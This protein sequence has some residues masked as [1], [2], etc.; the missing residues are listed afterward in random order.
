MKVGVIGCGVISRAYVENARAFDSFELVACADLDPAQ[1]IAL[2]KAERPRGRR[3]RRADRRSVDRRHPQP[4]AAA[5]ARRVITSQALAAGKHVYTEK[6]LATDEVEAA[7]LAREAARR[8]LRIGCA[9]DIFLGSA[10]QAG[11]AAIDEGAIGEPLS[12]SAAMLVG[13]QETWHPNPDI[14]YADGAG[15]L[16]DMGPY[17]LTAIVA[18]LGPIERV[19]GFASTRKLERT[20]EIGPRI[21]ERFIGHRRRRTRRRAMQ[22][23]NGVH[24]EPRRELRGARASTSAT[25]RSTA[26]RACSLLPDPN[27]FGGRCG[28]SAGAAAGRTCRTPRAAAPTPAAIGLHDMVEAI[29]AGSAAPRLRTAR[30]AR[31][32]GRPRHPA[33]RRGGAHRRDRVARRPAGAAAG[34]HR[35]LRG[36]RR[37]ARGCVPRRPGPG[38]QAVRGPKRTALRSRARSIS[39]ARSARRS[40]RHELAE[41]ARGRLGDGLNRTHE[42][43]LVRLARAVHAADLAHVLQRGGLDLERGGRRLVVMQWADVS[44]HAPESTKGP[45]RVPRSA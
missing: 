45:L 35:R 31:R 11:R 12:V 28:S 33:V 22:L 32:R 13:G 42:G 9:P 27:A 25:S 8:G 21:G 29:A 20:I 1:A 44:A 18:L 6:P 7:A 16:F 34:R 40:R 3:R 14:F 4:H 5:R 26:P 2:A 10:Y 38:R 30:R 19:A 36:R 37:D 41:Q 17:Y 39:R 24:R 23:A 43:L 15:P